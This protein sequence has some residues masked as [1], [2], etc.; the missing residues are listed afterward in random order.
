MPRA[1]VAPDF[2]KEEPE[3][4]VTALSHVSQFR[5]T[6]SAC[7]DVGNVR[8]R[9]EDAC[10]D[11][12]DGCIWA[13]ADGMGGHPEGDFASQAVTQTLAALPLHETLEARL[14]DVRDAMRD[15]NRALVE[16]AAR[17]QVSCVG[18]TVVALLAG[19][20]RCGCLWAGDSR[21]YR[22]RGG[23]LRQLTRDHNQVQRLLS[24]GL[25]TAE[26]ARHH[27]AQNIITRAVGAA[28]TLTLEQLLVDVADGDVFLL[29]SDG[30]T[31]E[32]DDADIA[33]V[34]ASD[35]VVAAAQQL[36][37]MALDAGGH[38]NVSVVIVRAEDLYGSD[39][40]QVNPEL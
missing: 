5:W 27:P 13:V 19:D 39:K 25:I 32:V 29:C 20:S 38:D 31:N 33:P 6:S 35:D 17:L 22:L 23:E 12:S 4:I 37:R 40:T 15:V 9:N 3:R 28:G 1:P 30:L 8:E 11:L 2:G 26:E 14:E 34:L 18:S 10:L 21:L 36:V 16:E 7:T 24:R